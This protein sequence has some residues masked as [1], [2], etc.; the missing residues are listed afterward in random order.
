MKTNYEVKELNVNMSLVEVIQGLEQGNI[1]DGIK[2]MKVVF[3]VSYSRIAEMMGINKVALMNGVKLETF[4]GVIK[5][6]KVLK[7]IE[8]LQG[9]YLGYPRRY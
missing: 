2:I 4:D 5:K 7:G 8:Q 1:V 9:L 3:G 6:S